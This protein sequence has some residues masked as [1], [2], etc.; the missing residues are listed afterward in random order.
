M[1][2]GVDRLLLILVTLFFGNMYK[3]I[4]LFHWFFVGRETEREFKMHNSEYLE[5]LFQEEKVVQ[6]QNPVKCCSWTGQQIIKCL[7]FLIFVTAF[8]SFLVYNVS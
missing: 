4:V 1:K 6:P 8:L 5:P 2:I 7:S 3:L